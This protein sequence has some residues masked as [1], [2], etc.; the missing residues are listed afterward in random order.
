MDHISVRLHPLPQEDA[1]CHEHAHDG[2]GEA[3]IGDGVQVGVI[4]CHGVLVNIEDEGKVGEVGAR[5]LGVG[6]VVAHLNVDQIVYV[7]GIGAGDRRQVGYKGLID[8]MTRMEMR[9]KIGMTRVTNDHAASS[10]S[11]PSSPSPS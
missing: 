11:L 9:V 7:W 8:Y 3:D 5:A 10:S 6:G 4:L 2:D 1:D